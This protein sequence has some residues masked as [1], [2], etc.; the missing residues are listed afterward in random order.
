MMWNGNIELRRFLLLSGLLT[1][2]GC[3]GTQQQRPVTPVSQ[4][5]RSCDPHQ[6]KGVWYHPQKHYDYEEEG[7]ASWYGPGFHGQPKAYGEVYD[8]EGISVAHRTLPLPTVALVTNLENGTSKKVLVCDRGPYAETDRRII[9]LS[10][11]VARDLGV[12]N[13]GLAKVNVKALPEESRMLSQY[14]GRFGRRGIDPSGRNWEIIYKEE[15]APHFEGDV[16]E[17]R[18][19][20]REE[21]LPVPLPLTLPKDPV[22]TQ[23]LEV[24]HIDPHAL[25]QIIDTVYKQQPSK[26]A[27]T[28]ANTDKPYFVEVGHYVQKKNADNAL[29]E[30]RPIAKGVIRQVRAA[31]KQRLY[32]V[33][34][35]PFPS[36]SKATAAARNLEAIGYNLASVKD[37]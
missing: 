20:L 13:A 21:V 15:I 36:L 25:D 7:H 18:S 24:A 37:S 16:G 17:P 3:A 35:G 33:K 14:L 8:E 32:A 2:A 31:K 34:L 9:D 4:V 28:P 29:A 6:I 12:L 5:C 22:F 1:L 23:M 11:G 27:Q 26:P 19:E 10:K 30:L